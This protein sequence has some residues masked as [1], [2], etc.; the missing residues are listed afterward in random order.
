W[1]VGDV[2]NFSGHASD[3][4][5]GNL[6]AASLSWSFIVHQGGNILSTQTFNGVAAGSV[7]A[8]DVAYPAY[9]ELQLTAV[10]SQGLTN[11]QSVQLNPQTTTL[12]VASNPSGLQ[13]SVD[14]VLGTS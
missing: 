13:L 3:F 14:G 5:D 2:I 8:P 7:L 9:L 4:E 11:T 6:P 12:T 10:D 1:Q